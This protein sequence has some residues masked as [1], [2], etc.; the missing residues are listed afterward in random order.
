MPNPQGDILRREF[1]SRITPAWE[2]IPDGVLLDLRGMQRLH[3][4]G[5]N[6]AESICA[7]ALREFPIWSA[8]LASSPLAAQLASLMGGMGKGQ[9][10]FSVPR[11]A[12]PSFLAG[13]SINVLSHHSREVPRLHALG[14]HTLGDLQVLPKNLLSAVF[15][16]VGDQLALDAWGIPSGNLGTNDSGPQ[17]LTV[18]AVRFAKPLVSHGGEKALRRALAM[19]ALC[20]V[21]APGRWSLS[22]C[23]S[24]GASSTV[25]ISG[26]RGESWPAWLV[27]LDDLWAKLPA[28]RQGIRQIRLLFRGT[29]DSFSSQLSLFEKSGDAQALGL[30]M[31]QI[32]QK[33][34]SSLAPASEA[35]LEKWGARWAKNP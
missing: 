5:A 29:D 20:K 25:E 4:P 26:P 14:V 33:F 22:V 17:S 28:H 27:L 30:A 6:G 31:F 11:G 21:S 18:A 35:L 8:G 3:G 2:V 23:W 12:V 13:F 16:T 9:K 10:L 32:S 34:E 1:Y 19:R 7:L 15:G 24:S